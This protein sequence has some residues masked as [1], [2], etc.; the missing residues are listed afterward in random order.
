MHPPA[1]VESITMGSEE[2]GVHESTHPAAAAQRQAWL[3]V[4]WIRPGSHAK[5]AAEHHSCARSCAG[6]RDVKELLVFRESSVIFF[7]HTDRG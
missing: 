1:R 2:S 6:A 3:G 5:R 4:S 7:P